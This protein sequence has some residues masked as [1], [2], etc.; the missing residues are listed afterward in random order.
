MLKIII[1]LV[2]LSI[3]LQ[4]VLSFCN[5]NRILINNAYNKIKNDISNKNEQELIE[6]FKNKLLELSENQRSAEIMIK[7]F[8]GLKESKIENKIKNI[9]IKS[10]FEDKKIN[11]KII[12]K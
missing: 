11:I 3:L 5:I 6:K 8:D 10:N 1:F 7:S 9:N 2:S 12:D 4:S